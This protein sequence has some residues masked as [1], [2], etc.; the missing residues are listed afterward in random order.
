MDNVVDLIESESSSEE[1]SGEGE[2]L[3]SSNVGVLYGNQ[4]NENEKLMNDSKRV[5]YENIRNRYFTPEI[6]KRRFTVDPSTLTNPLG[7]I[8]ILD[9][10]KLPTKNIIGFKMYKSNL[11]N[12]DPP[13][14][15]HV[16]LIIDEIPEI[17]CMKNETG[18]NIISR[19]PLILD[20]SSYYLYEDF[21]DDVYFHPISLNN[22]T[23][24]IDNE[25]FISFEITYLNIAE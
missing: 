4:F 3:L 20:T 25:G 11:K 15:K 9:D 12:K 7:K 24:S 18:I 5:D 8:S 16:D 22:L 6:T 23:L 19:I 21:V 13:T 2:E 14:A 1:S 10:L 17:A